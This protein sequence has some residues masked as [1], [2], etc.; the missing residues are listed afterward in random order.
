MFA[1]MNI[2][3]EETWKKI[4]QAIDEIYANNASKLSFE[5]LYR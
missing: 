4:K 2:D 5:E 1:V 3:P